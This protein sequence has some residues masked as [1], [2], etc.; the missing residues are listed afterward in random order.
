MALNMDQN[1]ITE[2]I[3]SFLE[4]IRQSEDKIKKSEIL[5]CHLRSFQISFY[6]SRTPNTTTLKRAHQREVKS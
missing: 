6:I 2:K 1:K 5:L 4:K 3:F